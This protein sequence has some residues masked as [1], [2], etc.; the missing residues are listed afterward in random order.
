MEPDCARAPA[1]R[2][3]KRPCDI[4]R[5]LR[6]PRVADRAPAAAPRGLRR[7]L[8]A[9]RLAWN[10]STFE[11]RGCESPPRSTGGRADAKSDF[12][13]ARFHISRDSQFP[14]AGQRQSRAYEFY[15]NLRGYTRSGLSQNEIA[16]G[17]Q[18]SALFAGVPLIDETM[19]ACR[20]V[21]RRDVVGSRFFGGSLFDHFQDRLVA[22]PGVLQFPELSS[23][24][25]R[26]ALGP[27]LCNR[28]NNFVGKSSQTHGLGFT[29]PDTQLIEPRELQDGLFRRA[30][31]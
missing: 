1:A 5:D 17:R 8:R 9:C 10:R 6:S 11:F 21:A 20:A 31:I 27:A 14:L 24:E 4:P 18:S 7:A 16:T 12:R 22:C 26:K 23:G 30:G 29:G 28:Q 2:L 3:P 13:P 19:A 25:N 15:F